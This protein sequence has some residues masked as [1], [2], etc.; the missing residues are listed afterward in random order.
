M[1]CKPGDLAIVIGAVNKKN[2]GMLVWVHRQLFHV[3]HLGLMVYRVGPDAY[4]ASPA[5]GVVWE[6]E[7]LGRPFDLTLDAG[8]KVTRAVSACADRGLWPLR[9]K[10]GEDESIA[11]GFRRAMLDGATLDWVEWIGAKAHLAAWRRA[12][13][14]TAAFWAKAK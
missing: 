8:T 10:P 5:D 7:S 2:I 4:P 1:R 9:D 13:P 11:W 14:A 3:Y 12:N 6:I